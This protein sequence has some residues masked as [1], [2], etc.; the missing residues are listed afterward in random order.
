MKGEQAGREDVAVLVPFFGIV[1]LMPPLL[2]L[3]EGL[4]APFGVPLEVLYL[5]GVWLLVIA[6]AVLLSRRKQ[7]RETTPIAMQ[8]KNMRP[9]SADPPGDA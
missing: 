2:N 7:F 3:F 5:F 4:R 1:L 8:E 6:G 9:S